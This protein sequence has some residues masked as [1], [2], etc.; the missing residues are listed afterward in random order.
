MNK[1]SAFSPPAVGISSLLTIFAVLCLVVFALLCIS[2][3]QS[4]LRLARAAETAITGYYEA[5]CQAETILAAL[6]RGEHPES[7]TEEN[8]IYTYTCPISQTQ[9]LAVEVA[10]TGD[11][12]DILRWQAVSTAQWQADEQL[13]VWQ[14]EERSN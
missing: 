6:R 1:R 7:V 5:D 12:Y 11:A 4:E 3:T 13:P 9:V 2:T 10:V 8:G 14:G